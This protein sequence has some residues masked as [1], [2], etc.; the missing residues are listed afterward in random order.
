MPHLM[1]PEPQGGGSLMPTTTH[2]KSFFGLDYGIYPL[3][4]F[5]GVGVVM[6]I[7]GPVTPYLWE[8]VLFGDVFFAFGYLMIAG[9]VLFLRRHRHEM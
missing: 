5:I 4:T 3:L 6:G 9:F 2:R 8:N 7:I 1:V